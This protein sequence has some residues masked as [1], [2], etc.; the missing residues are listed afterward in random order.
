MAAGSEARERVRGHIRQDYVSMSQPNYRQWATSLMHLGQALPR[1]LGIHKR[2]SEIHSSSVRVVAS[3]RSWRC[4]LCLHRSILARI[5]LPAMYYQ[6]P[7]IESTGLHSRCLTLF[8]L[9]GGRFWWKHTGSNRAIGCSPQEAA[10]LL[11]FLWSRPDSR[12]SQKT[13]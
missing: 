5:D 4:G 6:L 10:T 8:P 12:N 9:L 11:S 1:S 3:R 2:Q 13:S 7:P